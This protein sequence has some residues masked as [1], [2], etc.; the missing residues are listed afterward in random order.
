MIPAL[1]DAQLGA[2]VL[3]ASGG[4]GV[5]V[6]WWLRRH[7]MVSVRHLY[8]ATLATILLDGTAVSLRAWVAAWVLVPLTVLVVA[9][10]SVGRRWRLS[11][12]G[13]GEELR[14]H[15]QARRW[16]WQPSVSRPV[17]ERVWIAT[18]GQIVRERQ[19]P[20]GEPYVPLTTDPSGPRMPRRSGRHVFT[21]GATG[22]GKTTSVLRCAAAGVLKDHAALLFVDQKGDPPAEAFLR[23]LAAAAGVPFILFDPRAADSDRWQPLWGTRPAEVVAR[24]S[25]AFRRASRTTPTSC[26]Y[27]SASSRPSCTRR[28]A[29]HPRSP[30]SCGTRRCANSS[31]SVSSPSGT[32]P[33]TLSCGSACS[34]TAGSCNPAKARRHSPAGLCASSS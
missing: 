11:D 19:W 17:G 21:A 34:A 16:L 13:A 32:R 23:S 9:G 30:C 14:A 1:R 3:I 24:A 26:A 33:S 25:P 4:V 20:S 27:M 28:G 31:M 7:T 10:S 29:G 22:S 2:L 6:A 15:E 18:Q 5:G 8:L 12:L